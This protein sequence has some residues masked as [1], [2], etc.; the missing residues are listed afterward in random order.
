MRFRI[1]N[2]AT[3]KK[4]QRQQTKEHWKA[5]TKECF[6][7]FQQWGYIAG[8]LAENH[9]ASVFQK[10]HNKRITMSITVR[11]SEHRGHANLGWL[12]SY[13]SQYFSFFHCLNNKNSL[14]NLT[15]IWCK[16]RYH[17]FSFADYYDSKFTGFHDLLV[18]NE[19]RVAPGKGFGAHP[20]E[21]ME[22]FSYGMYCLKM[23]E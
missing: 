11:K 18:I 13:H 16:N 4:K 2:F 21:E 15:I 19:D 7:S 5:G 17:T 9:S 10:Q 8:P 12:N 20:H 14:Y 1:K 23:Q 6:H 3:E 22:I